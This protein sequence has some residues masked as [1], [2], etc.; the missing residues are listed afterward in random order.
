MEKV[1]EKQ[2]LAL[3]QHFHLIF[4]IFAKLPTVVQTYS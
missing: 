3:Q 2:E 4:Q 1:V